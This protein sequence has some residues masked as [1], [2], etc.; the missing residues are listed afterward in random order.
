MPR[1]HRRSPLVVFAMALVDSVAVLAAFALAVRFSLPDGTGY[2]AWFR[3]HLLDFIL[4]VAVWCGAATDQ[5]R[6][7]SYRSESVRVQVLNVVRSVAITLM[8]TFFLGIFLTQR[9]FNAPFAGYFSVIVLAVLLVLRETE[10]L[11]LWNWRRKGGN[12]RR[13]L[14]VGANDRGHHLVVVI[15]DHIE[16]GY[17]FAGV[18]DDD[19]E[20]IACL[21]G[22]DIPYL[23]P[24][25]KLEDILLD[26]VI[27]EVYICL[28]VRSYYETITSM[29][30]LCEGIGTPVRLVTDLFPRRIAISRVRQFDDVPILSLSA[31]PEAQLALAVKR[32]VD[33]AVS[34]AFLATVA[35]WLF[36]LVALVIKLESRGPVF[37]AQERV[38]LHRRRFRMLKF[39]SMVANAEELKAKLADANEADGPVFKMKN[40][41]RMTRVGRFIRKTSID[42]LPQFLNVFLGHMSLVGP[43][44]PVPSEVEKYTW[45]QRR[46][47]SVR[48]GITG[49]QQV[50][51]R[52]DLTF[53]Q[54]VELDLHYI[55]N[56]SPMED[57]RILLHTFEAVF[58]ARGAR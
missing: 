28:P 10:R 41:P 19:P 11:M 24:L 38:G 44:P 40:D 25:D 53:E 32:M 26:Q 45:D 49:L 31:V 33:L 58:L 15:S 9:V 36:P 2:P 57:I 21:E 37:F 20:R 47:L 52:S 46:R 5:R 48:P 16:Y 3:E 22:H 4:F 50:S 43:R 51:G 8:L 34:G 1:G 12:Q 35:W 27:D 29:A 55:D 6:F 39:R 17:E 13:L 56:W 14:L 23:G 42:E 7:I 30:Y 18:I 54:W